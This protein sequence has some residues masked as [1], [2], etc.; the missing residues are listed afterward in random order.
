VNKVD[1]LRAKSKL[2]PMLQRVR[3]RPFAA[4]VPISART[5]E[6][7]ESLADEIMTRLPPGPP[8]FPKEQKTDRDVAFRGAEIIREK[9]MTL[10]RQEVP[11]GLTVEIEHM[12]RGEDGRWLVHGLIWLERESHKP[13]V[14]GKEGAL[15]KQAGSE[16]RVELAKLLGE[17]VHLELWVKVREHW[18]DREQEL[19][20]LGF[21]VE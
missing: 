14:I 16:A 9:L 10:L 1:S 5:G 15:L 13:I 8:L 19:K 11:Y 3:E 18:S 7:L 12:A 6:N 21:D 20:R 4:F 2:L 17:R